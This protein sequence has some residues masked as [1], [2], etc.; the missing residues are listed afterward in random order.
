MSELGEI[1]RAVGSVLIPEVRTAQTAIFPTEETLPV[2]LELFYT[3]FSIKPSHRQGALF[4]AKRYAERMGLDA[5]DVEAFAL[6]RLREV[7][8]DETE[9]GEQ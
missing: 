1:Q 3:A 7:V 4:I 5:G 8:A 9:E 2:A 6:A